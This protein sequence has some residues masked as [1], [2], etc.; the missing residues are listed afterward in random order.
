MYTCIT[1]NCNNEIYDNGDYSNCEYCIKCVCG[2]GDCINL[3]QIWSQLCN[4]CEIEIYYNDNGN[5]NKHECEINNCKNIILP[6]HTYCKHHSC[7]FININLKSKCDN[8]IYENNKCF[9]HVFWKPICHKEY[10]MNVQ[11]DVWKSLLILF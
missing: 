10:D 7:D 1:S 4:D 5:I 3:K 11:N 2:L 9:D 8:I 6:H